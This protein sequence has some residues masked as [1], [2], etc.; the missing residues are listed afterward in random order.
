VSGDV[1]QTLNELERK[2]RE[3]QAELRAPEVPETHVQEPPAPPSPPAPE[4]PPP[5]PPPAPHNP[6]Q[7]Q[8]DE[9]LRFRDQLT[10]AAN[11]LVEDYTRLVEQLERVAHAPPPPTAA[12]EHLTFPVPAPEPSS[13]ES[14]LYA[15]HVAVEAA[16]FDDVGT[17]AIF[18]SALRS[19]SHAEE[20]H[21]RSFENGRAEFDLRL[22]GEVALVFELRR[23]SD[24]A[25]DVEDAEPGRL[26]LTM[27]PPGDFPFP[28]RP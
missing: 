6:L 21:V 9:L 2:L 1:Q 4:P 27:H 28:M 16:P 20:V 5:P 7:D 13:S 10:A 12:A 11:Q 24:H 22:G 14:A 23:A 17:L 8:L 3:L 15:G 18:E 26:R 19:V 25:F